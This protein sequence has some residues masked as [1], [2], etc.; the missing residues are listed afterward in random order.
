MAYPSEWSE[1]QVKSLERMF[2]VGCSDQIISEAVGKSV[3]GV[4][5]KR[6]KMGMYRDGHG[7]PCDRLHV[8]PHKKPITDR[9]HEVKLRRCLGPD[10][11]RKFKSSWKGNRLCPR[12]KDLV[13]G[14]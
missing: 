11:G 7:R 12:C 13:A 6:I 10:C 9:K 14:M 5:N 1:E 4:R 8:Y 3:T 2:E